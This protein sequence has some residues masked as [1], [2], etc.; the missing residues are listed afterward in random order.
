MAKDKGFSSIGRDH[1][2]AV[3]LPKGGRGDSGF[4]RFGRDV[5]KQRIPTGGT[6]PKMGRDSKFGPRI[7]K[8]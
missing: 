8:K 5:M 4:T 6:V 7:P 2:T 1:P 3:P